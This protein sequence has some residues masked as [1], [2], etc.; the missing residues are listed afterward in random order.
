MNFPNL[1]CFLISSLFLNNEK[2]FEKIKFHDAKPHAEL[3]FIKILTIT[4]YFFYFACKTQV[5][6]L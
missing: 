3:R 6:W 5:K 2:I 4:R 1:A